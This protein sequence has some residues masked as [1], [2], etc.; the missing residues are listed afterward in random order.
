MRTLLPPETTIELNMRFDDAHPREI[1]RW[2][3]EEPEIERVAVASA[4]QAEGTCVIHMATAVRPEVPIL[5]L[6]TGFGQHTV[7]EQDQ[8]PQLAQFVATIN[9]GF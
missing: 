2:A 7:F 1:I 9:V 6:E 3:L 5:F 4:F 8:L